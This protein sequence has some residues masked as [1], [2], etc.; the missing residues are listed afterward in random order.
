M[1]KSIFQL[2]AQCGNSRAGTVTLPQFPEFPIH[3]PQFMPVGTAGTVKSLSTSDLDNLGAEIILGNTYHLYLR[4]GHE[5]MERLGG[6]HKFM[7]WKRP[8]L[9][10]SGGFQ[11][12]S[13]ADLRKITDEGVHFQSHLDGSS[14]F[15][16]PESSMQIQRALGSDVVMAFDECPPFSATR[17]EVAQ[18]MERTFHW[19]RRGLDVELKPHQRRFGIIQGGLHEDLRKISIDQITSL[20]FDGY[21]LGGFSIGEPPQLM[22]EVVGKV[23]IYLPALTPRYLMGVGRPEDL[24]EAVRAGI[25]LFDCVM[26]TRNAR[27]GQLFTRKGKINIKNAAYIEDQEPLDSDCKCYTCQTVS[28]AYL[29][30]LFISKELLSARLNTIHNL[31]FYLD[32]MKEM[33]AAIQ[34][35]RF[36]DWAKGFY[37]SYYHGQKKSNSSPS[38]L[39]RNSSLLN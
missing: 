23:A 19:A 6:L 24:V 2:E 5:R 34:Q 11:V 7:N 22:Q 12:F 25:D 27:N 21:A 31:Q 16:T 29:R 38:E 33:R 9:T 20:P 3:T 18:A 14:H 8:I 28:R 32:L 26:P 30:H 13:L 36:D 35:N 10:D 4:P 1:T 15:F 39:D 37:T 17:D